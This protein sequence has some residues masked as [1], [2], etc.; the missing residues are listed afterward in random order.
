MKTALNRVHNEVALFSAN[1]KGVYIHKPLCFNQ[2]VYCP[3]TSEIINS[4]HLPA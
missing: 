1:E 4:F 3:F 2:H